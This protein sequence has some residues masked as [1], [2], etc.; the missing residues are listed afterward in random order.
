MPEGNQNINF[1]V[2]SLKFLE[3]DLNQSFQQMRHYDG[4]IA[5]LLKFIFTGY[6]ALIG[7]AVGLYRFPRLKPGS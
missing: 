3:N 6:V 5:D 7:L 1:H 4:Q 2:E